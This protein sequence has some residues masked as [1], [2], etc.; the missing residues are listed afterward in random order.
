VID[1]VSGS[2]GGKVVALDAKNK[3]VTTESGE[4]IKADLINIIP[5]QRAGKLAQK[6]GLTNKSGWC[7][8]N[9]NSME[10]EIHKEVYV[11]GDSSIADAMPKSGFSANSQAK[12][13]AKAIAD[14]LQ[15]KALERAIYS[16]VCYSLAGKDYGVSIAAIY[17]VRDG[18]IR[19]KGK[20][21][22]V[23]EI[24]EKPAQPILESLYQ[25]NW[26]RQFVTDVFS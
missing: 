13:C 5:N 8:I 1:W 6:L 14:T 3:T 24:T 15:G 23:S 17:E 12:V 25:K 19:P 18:K 22:G 2:E 9:R 26:Q 4:S 20:S 21:A 7:P 11:L 16:N 10:S